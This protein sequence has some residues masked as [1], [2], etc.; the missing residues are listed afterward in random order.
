MPSMI[1]VKCYV[2]VRCQVHVRAIAKYQTSSICS[3]VSLHDDPSMKYKNALNSYKRR[4][5]VVYISTVGEVCSRWI[6]YY[7]DCTTSRAVVVGIEGI[8]RE[9]AADKGYIELW[10]SM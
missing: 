6:H 4:A 8:A 7:K 3:N 2:C 10:Y 9:I 5:C 1:A